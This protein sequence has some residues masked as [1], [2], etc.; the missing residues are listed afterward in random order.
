MIRAMG[1]LESGKITG[2]PEYAPLGPYRH[3][4]AHSSLIGV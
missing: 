1:K 3:P 4:M 2:L